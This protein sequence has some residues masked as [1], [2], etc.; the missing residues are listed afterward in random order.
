[1]M[2]HH[3]HNLITDTSKYQ[4]KLQAR[5]NPVTPTKLSIHE[6]ELFSL[7]KLHTLNCSTRDMSLSGNIPGYF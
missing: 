4:I 3:G 6:E 5:I 1:M 2:W 7:S